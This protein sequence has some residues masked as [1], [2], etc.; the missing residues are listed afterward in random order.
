M[1]RFFFIPMLFGVSTAER[2]SS[3]L[4]IK[5]VQ[6]ALGTKPWMARYVQ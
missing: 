6:V 5:L 2:G 1:N 4:G 3:E